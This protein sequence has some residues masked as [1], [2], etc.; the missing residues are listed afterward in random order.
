LTLPARQAEPAFT[1][2]PAKAADVTHYVVGGS[3]GQGLDDGARRR[4][5]ASSAARSTPPIMIVPAAG[6][7]SR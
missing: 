7:S 6:S 2:S 3:N 4:C 1:D 5:A